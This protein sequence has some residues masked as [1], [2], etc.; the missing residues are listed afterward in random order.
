M[1]DTE[2]SER[3]SLPLV[4]TRTE[5]HSERNTLRYERDET[6][7]FGA[8]EDKATFT[9]RNATTSTFLVDQKET[10]HIDARDTPLPYGARL[11]DDI[12][13]RTETAMSQ[14]HA[15]LV[16]ELVLEAQ[17]RATSPR[18]KQS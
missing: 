6:P 14:A 3:L 9:T 16:A 12:V 2:E 7:G 18:L 1:Y 8:R 15:F 10:R 13:N 11:M 5:K 17:A 4:D